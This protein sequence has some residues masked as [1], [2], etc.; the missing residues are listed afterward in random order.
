MDMQCKA[1]IKSFSNYFCFLSSKMANTKISIC[2]VHSAKPRRPSYLF[3]DH[4]AFIHLGL[5]AIGKASGPTLDIGSIESHQP[6]YGMCVWTF[7]GIS[8]HS[9]LIEFY[10]LFT[11]LTTKCMLNKS[12]SPD[13][14]IVFAQWSLPNHTE[15][16]F[17]PVTNM[18]VTYKK[19]IKKYRMFYRLV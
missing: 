9:T 2:K 15:T 4:N 16:L 11:Y 10:I 13:S 3:I 14:I 5:E 19:K 17:H 1:K 18:G 6:T 12:F 7:F 8:T